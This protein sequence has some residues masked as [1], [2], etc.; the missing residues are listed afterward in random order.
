MPRVIEDA[1]TL[2]ELADAWADEPEMAIDVEGDGLFRYRARLCTVQLARPD[3]TVVVDTIVI[4]EREALARL[5]GADGPRKIVHDTSYD[6]R[7]LFESG[8]VLGNVFDTALAA[9]FLGEPSTGLAALLEKRFGVHLPKEQQKQDWGKRPFTAEDLDYLS[10]DVSHLLALG[11]QLEEEVR[12]RGIEDEVREESVYLLE[13][14][15]EEPPEPPPPWTRIKGRDELSETGLAI[16]REVAQVREE[17][18]R[19]WDVP[20]FKVTGN[21][22]LLELAKRRPKTPGDFGRIRGLQ[23][24]RIQ[25]LRGKLL[26]A[27]LRGEASGSVPD[28]E[29]PERTPRPP[30]EEREKKKRR[31]QALTSWR[32]AE[33]GARGVDPQ[34]VLPGH[35]VNDLADRGASTLDDLRAIPG[36]GEHRVTRYAGVL[37]PLLAEEP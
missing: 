12:T 36:F 19:K 7:L 15:L 9:R 21:R 27:V 13:R 17:A 24:G 33:A 28:E 37:L 31:Q 11:R 14:A 1:A 34:V 26:D 4:D 32:R 10:A 6:A 20:P 29:R 5:L 18:A 23:R 35:C 2:R 30:V 25:S 3:E 22:E 16:L 8:V